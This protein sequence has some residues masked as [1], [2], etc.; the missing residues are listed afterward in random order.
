MKVDKCLKQQCFWWT[1]VSG[2]ACC[3]GGWHLKHLLTKIV[4]VS[5][6]VGSCSSYSQASRRV[7]G[8]MWEDVPLLILAIKLSPQPEVRC[9]SAYLNRARLTL[10]DIPSHCSLQYVLKALAFLFLPL[11]NQ[12]HV[13]LTF[14]PP[15]PYLAVSELSILCD[16]WIAEH[17]RNYNQCVCS[18]WH[19]LSASL[20]LTTWM[21]C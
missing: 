11:W 9:C 15:T 13:S 6:N 10:P 12:V 14:Q 4:C 19:F 2:P 3:W 1:S 17:E 18:V 21:Y 5:F 16:L 8:S 7:A 20:P